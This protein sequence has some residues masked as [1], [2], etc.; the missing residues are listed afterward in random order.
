MLGERIDYSLSTKG[1][2]ERMQT[3]NLEEARF[4]VTV[5]QRKENWP[6]GQVPLAGLFSNCY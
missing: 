3:V 4:V 6:K 2:G 1:C 5:C